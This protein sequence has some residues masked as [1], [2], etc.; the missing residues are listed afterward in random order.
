MHLN[1][2]EKQFENLGKFKA[3]GVAGCVGL[4]QPRSGQ[5]GSSKRQT[6]AG[7][8]SPSQTMV[9]GSGRDEPVAHPA[10]GGRAPSTNCP[11]SAG[12]SPEMPR[13]CSSK[14]AMGSSKLEPKLHRMQRHSTHATLT[15]GSK[16][17]LL[18]KRRG[19]AGERM[20]EGS[21]EAGRSAASP[22]PQGP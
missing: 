11:P 12:S 5:H 8:R 3:L 16:Q 7:R 1:L 10:K 4:K 22:P 6:T 19:L 14:Q 20:R 9:G 13:D 17:P 18:G 2:M 15:S 21:G